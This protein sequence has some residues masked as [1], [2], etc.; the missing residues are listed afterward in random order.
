MGYAFA[1]A[2]KRGMVHDNPFANLPVA[3]SIA[4][5]RARAD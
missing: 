3:K 1:W 2:V 4:K 5:R